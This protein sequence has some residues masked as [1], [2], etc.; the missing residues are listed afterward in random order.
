V[1][2]AGPLGCGAELGA[3]VAHAARN[4]KAIS[5]A[6]ILMGREHALQARLPQCWTAP[7]AQA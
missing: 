3:A 1:G 2:A 7:R 6:A 4:I 5:E